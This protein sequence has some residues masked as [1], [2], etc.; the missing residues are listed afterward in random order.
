MNIET[1]TRIVNRRSRVLHNCRL[2][3]CRT[4]LW[5]AG[6]VQMRFRRMGVLALNA[7]FVSVALANMPAANAVPASA[8]AARPKPD[9]APLN[10]APAAT[11][12]PVAK[13][14]PRT[15]PRALPR[16]LPRAVRKPAV[17]ALPAETT[18]K[19]RAILAA[20]AMRE[21]R[22]GLCII[23]LGTVSG[24]DVFPSEPLPTRP[25]GAGQAGGGSR[26]PV[27]FAVDAD[28]R[29]MPASNLKLYTAA[30]A[31]RLLEAGRTFETR[32]ETDTPGAAAAGALDATELSGNVY[33]VGGGDPS[34]SSDDLSAL[35][36]QVA[37]R[38]I[39]RI[40]GDIIGDGTAFNADNSGGRYPNGWTL[41]DTLW[42]YG[43]EVGALAVNRNHVDV[44]VTGAAD[45][46]EPATLQVEPPADGFPIRFEVVT[47]AKPRTG[48]TARASVDF[49]RSGAGGAIVASLSVSGRVAP[50]QK[51]TQGIAVPDPARWAAAIFKRLLQENGVAVEGRALSAVPPAPV[52]PLSPAAPDATLPV[53]TQSAGLQKTALPWRSVLV[54]HHSAPLRMLLRRFLKNS[55]NLYGEML[56]RAAALY[57]LPTGGASGATAQRAHASL[58]AWLKRYG[59]ATGGLSLI[60][61][62]GLSRYNLV[63][64]RAT[65]QLLT[66]IED[67][68][69][70]DAI[71]DA[72]PIAGVDGSLRNRMK[73]TPA[74]GVVRAKTG[75][76]S[77][78]STLS[79][80]VTTRGGKRLAVSLLTNFARDGNQSRRLQ[81]ALFTALAQSPF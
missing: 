62:S 61:G 55:D 52:A 40:R 18:R 16:A 34:L 50:G 44:T 63:T 39:K 23:E 41:D 36:R 10:A 69:D 49:D 32:V 3:N 12:P 79:G 60:D 46:G 77:I 1:N 19:L 66:L 28:K 81:D 68:P 76:F 20:P 38:G 58:L 37:A 67:L 26:Q 71:W 14:V 7:A 27:L 57:A 24:A 13:P 45:A 2:H 4:L 47:G 8:A 21:A 25:G 80:Y 48:E 74:M 30:I 35:A 65:A 64:P 53:S 29:F 6:G 70:G 17:R 72:L 11:R 78:V 43:P 75:T 56:L 5:P 51:V 15:V 73:N 31:L 59:V 42:Y 33:L 9:T 22:V 54:R